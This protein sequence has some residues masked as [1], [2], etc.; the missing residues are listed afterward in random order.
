MNQ[1]LA[2]K[3]SADA[4]IACQ[5]AKGQKRIAE[6]DTFAGRVLGSRTAPCVMRSMESSR[7]LSNLVV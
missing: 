6:L 2:C 5:A 3:L 7:G 1:G 4:L